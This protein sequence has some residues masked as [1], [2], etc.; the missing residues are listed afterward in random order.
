METVK[1]ATSAISEKA[2]NWARMG[3]KLSVLPD[4]KI[5]YYR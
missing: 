1:F 5:L 3:P 4:C 2:W